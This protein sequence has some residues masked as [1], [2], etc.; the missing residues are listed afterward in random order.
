LPV[1]L[2]NSLSLIRILMVPLYMVFMLNEKPY[3]LLI[4]AGIFVVAGC[5]DIL[6][7]YIARKQSTVSTMG[8][9]LD[10][11]ADKLLISAGLI[12]LVYL[13]YLSPWIAFIIIT[14]E[15]AVTWLRLIL[16]ADGVI[17]AASGLGK[18]KNILQIVAVVSLTVHAA[19]QTDWFRESFLRFFLFL[20]SH[21]IAPLALYLALLL[22]VVSGLDYFYK[23]RKGIRF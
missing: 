11:L 12:T 2:A 1:N 4:A 17:V 20:P 14:R 8:K 15:F 19:F 21:I 13:G 7:G 16:A 3:G 10:P 6:D 22:T 23:N 5:T 9:F 18:L